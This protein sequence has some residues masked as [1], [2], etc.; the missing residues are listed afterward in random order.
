MAMA[1]LWVS[2]L[3]AACQTSLASPVQAAPSNDPVELA[4]QFVRLFAS[5]GLSAGAA[6]ALMGEGAVSR[7]EGAFWQIRR[8]DGQQQIVMRAVE[9]GKSL[10][11]SELRLDL[12]A[13]LLLSDL[14]KKFGPW[15]VVA[16]SK[17]SSVSFQVADS[18]PTV[19]LARLLTPTADADSPVV[20]LQLR[21]DPSP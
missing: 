1:I 3:L 9:A 21:R 16:E 20:S 13:G 12:N 17:T 14:E 8:K 2:L 4:A 7:R 5:G 19:V 18:V 15:K 11:D 6:T 10:D